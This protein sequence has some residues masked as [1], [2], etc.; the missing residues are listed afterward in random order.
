M[1]ST[2]TRYLCNRAPLGWGGTG[3]SHHGC[4]AHKSALTVWCCNVNM[5]L[6]SE[7]FFQHLVESMPILTE[8]SGSSTNWQVYC[9][10]PDC[11]S[12]H[13]KLSYGNILKSPGVDQLTSCHKHFTV[14]MLHRKHLDFEKGACVNA[15]V[16]MNET[17]CVKPL[18]CSSRVE[19]WYTRTSPHHEELSGSNPGTSKL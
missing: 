11:S 6:I 19:K 10:I 3:D 12:F 9:L 8:A 18:E 16:W 1:A 14:W 7:Q 5:D 2:I 15:C 13:V 17:C 4:E